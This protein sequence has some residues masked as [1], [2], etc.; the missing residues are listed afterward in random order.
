M[1]PK[2]KKKKQTQKLNKNTNWEGRKQTGIK[3]QKHPTGRHGYRH[4]KAEQTKII[5]STKIINKTG[6]NKTT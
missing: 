3:S 2:L 1:Q 6:N 5:T 4:R